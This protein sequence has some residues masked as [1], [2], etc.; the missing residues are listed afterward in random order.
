[1]GSGP[2]AFGERLEKNQD[3]FLLA[4]SYDGNC[5]FAQCRNLH[6]DVSRKRSGVS[7]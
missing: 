3:N 5:P 7:N 1:M 2:S 6:A 4:D